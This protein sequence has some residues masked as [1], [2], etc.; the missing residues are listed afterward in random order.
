MNFFDFKDWFS[1]LK[2]Q[3]FEYIKNLK[4]YGFRLLFDKKSTHF[5]EK[6]IFPK[7]PW[8]NN[9]KKIWFKQKNIDLKKWLF[10][11]NKKI[12]NECIKKKI[13]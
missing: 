11:K 4:Y 9:Y 7:Y 6:K 13:I 8:D 1:N 12:Y 5:K 3:D 10:Y 2:D